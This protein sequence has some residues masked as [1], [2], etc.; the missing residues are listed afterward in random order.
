MITQYDSLEI[1]QDSTLKKLDAVHHGFFTRFGGV[2]S[3]IYSSLNCAYPSNDH[4]DN[5]SENRKRAM[6]YFR[7]SLESLVTVRNIHSN[8]AILVG[9]PWQE[10]EK[11]EADA[12][13]TILPN[14]VLG[15]DSADCPI[16]LF[17]DEQ[18]G[19]I[20]LAH[21]GWRGAKSG[22]IENTVEK[23]VLL[24]AK[25]QHISAAISPCISQTS[26]EVNLDFQKS[27]LADNQANKNF[28]IPSAKKYHFLFDLPGYVKNRL[29]KLN[30]KSVSSE[31]AID[32]YA[33]E[34]FFSCRRALHRGEA[35]FGGHFS[36][37]S[38]QT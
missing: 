24:G 16:I 9:H 36:C 15:S 17:A 7:S 19:V 10:Q 34:R 30:L 1:L 33:D 6:T 13:V 8:V 23:M 4:P 20:G 35:W 5:V 3:G 21:A 31:T 29:L 22:I 12:M 28:F 37:I 2:S 32:T 38:I 11:P 25:N 26:Y 18:A 27:F 14:I